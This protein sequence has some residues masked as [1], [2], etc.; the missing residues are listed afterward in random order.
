[1]PLEVH[2]RLIY[3]LLFHFLEVSLPTRRACQLL[4]GQWHRLGL[5]LLEDQL[6]REIVGE[7]ALWLAQDLRWR[8]L[9]AFRLLFRGVVILP[10]FDESLDFRVLLF[11]LFGLVLDLTGQFGF[12][13][14]LHVRVLLVAHLVGFL[15]VFE[16]L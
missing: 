6:I 15:V 10:F 12:A 7:H 1:M 14:V 5:R 16:G 4:Q 11:V 2:L 13:F 9:G 8:L 3:L